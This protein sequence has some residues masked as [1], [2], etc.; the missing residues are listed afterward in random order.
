M[1]AIVCYAM[2]CILPVSTHLPSA[3]YHPTDKAGGIHLID[4]TDVPLVRQADGVIPLCSVVIGRRSV[5][6][7]VGV[8]IIVVAIVIIVV[9][10]DAL[11]TIASI[12]STKLFSAI[13]M[14]VA[15]TVV[16]QKALK[17]PTALTSTDDLSDPNFTATGAATTTDCS[18]P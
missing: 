3:C 9:L 6:M 7:T 10:C 14:A 4:A 2:S 15:T 13:F 5:E 18:R 1:D 8:V 12:F 16:S 11:L 17:E